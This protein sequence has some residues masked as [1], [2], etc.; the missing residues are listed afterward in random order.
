MPNKKIVIAVVIGWLF[1]L[2][3][4]PQKLPMFGKKG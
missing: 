4:P 3:L 1:A 2:V